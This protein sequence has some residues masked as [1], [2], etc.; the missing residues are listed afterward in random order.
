MTTT[1][2]PGAAWPELHDAQ[3]AVLAALIAGGSQPRADIARALALSRTSLTRIT[4]ELIELGFVTVGETSRRPTRGR[5][6]ELIDLVP[7]SAHFVGV[8]LTGDALYAVV[9]DLASQ[10]VASK[11]TDLAERDAASVVALIS[12]TAHELLNGLD[13][14]SA[15]GV[16][17]AGDVELVDGDQCIVDSAFLGWEGPVPLARLI[18]EASGLPATVSN[19][20][21]ALTAAHHWFGAGVGTRSLVVVG[22]G[23]GIGTG[24]VIENRL[25]TGAHG[26]QGKI[27]HIFVPARG[28][29]RCALGHT[30]CANALVT[31]P[32]IAE[33]AGHTL[34]EYP[35]VLAAARAGDPDALLAFEEASTALGAIVAHFINVLDPE[36]VVVTGEGI[37]MVELAPARLRAALADR[38]DP[39]A[40]REVPVDVQPFAFDQYAWG[41][42]IT[43]IRRQFGATV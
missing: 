27:G 36:K 24:I 6:V 7:A 25:V 9:T 29:R 3:R 31:M 11:E 34:K 42:A 40:S 39:R 16:C 21:N 14:P 2:G 41:A 20:V 10:V 15:I 28:T 12:R 23:A 5:P 33:N 19:D 43:A 30:G 32:G 4:R 38:L 17:L 13:R 35:A 1:W 37:D 22:V 8:K 26:R 18:A